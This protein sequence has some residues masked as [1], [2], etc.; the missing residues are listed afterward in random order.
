MK[1]SSLRS[2]T[3]A[4]L[5]TFLQTLRFNVWATRPQRLTFR[6][7]ASRQESCV[8][9]LFGLST[10]LVRNWSSLFLNKMLNW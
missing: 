8:P 5:P 10:A 7:P 1:H 4:L 2:L 6:R 3:N 9:Q